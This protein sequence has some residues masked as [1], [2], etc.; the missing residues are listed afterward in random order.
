MKGFQKQESGSEEGQKV[1]ILGLAYE[2]AMKRINEQQHGF[3]TLATQALLWVTCGRRPLKTTELQH[4]LA[5]KV[6]EPALDEGDFPQMADIVSACAGLVTVDED[7]G[8]I[9]L[10]H[11][12]TQEYFERTQTRWFPEAET[13]IATVCV[14]YLSFD[15]FKSGF[16][17]TQGRLN[18][19]LRTNALYD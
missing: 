1:K 9:R 7:S 15:V 11:Y 6:G 17:C 10:V 13:E 16:C 2:G 4:A 18:E 8:I 14:A 3:K 5:T 12:T 19:R